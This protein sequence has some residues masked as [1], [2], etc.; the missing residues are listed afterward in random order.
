MYCTRYPNVLLHTG[1]VT[2]EVWAKLPDQDGVLRICFRPT[3]N[4]ATCICTVDV[5]APIICESFT[6]HSY[7][8]TVDPCYSDSTIENP[9]YSEHE[10]QLTLAASAIVKF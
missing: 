4:D 3:R 8:H 2:I 7:I 1:P 9:A 6:Y 5:E 10:L